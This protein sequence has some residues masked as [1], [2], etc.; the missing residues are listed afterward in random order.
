PNGQFESLRAGA[1]ATDTFH[2]TV[3]DGSGAT[4]T[5]TATVTLTGETDARVAA[6]ISAAAQEDTGNP[7]TLTASYTDVDV[8]DTHTFS[9]DTTGTVGT[10]VNNGDG[11][12]SYNPN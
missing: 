8:G 6:A 3:T 11:T 4:S 7:V 9:V 10:V 12:F 1:N 5:Q 2:Y